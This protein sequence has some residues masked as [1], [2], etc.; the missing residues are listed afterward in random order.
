MTIASYSCLIE[1]LKGGSNTVTDL[2]SRV[3]KD[4][5]EPSE[6]GSSAEESLPDISDKTSEIGVLNSKQF[7]QESFSKN[8]TSNDELLDKP[9]P[10]I[11]GFDLQ[12]EQARDAEIHDILKQLH[13]EGPAKH[14]LE[15]T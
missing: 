11:T 6:I 15:N 7:P 2:L 9:Y 1:Y 8:E 14:S 12:K 3:P 10:E 13:W 5:S 4:P